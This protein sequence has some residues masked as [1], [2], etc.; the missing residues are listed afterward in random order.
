MKAI[1][2]ITGNKGKFSE[3]QEKAKTLDVKIIQKDL[4]YPEIQT[5]SLEE[6]ARYGVEYIQ[7][8]FPH[9]FVIEDAGIFIDALDGFPGVYSKYVFYSIGL[10]GILKLLKDKKNRKAVFRSIYAYVEPGKEPSFFNGEC[11]G[12][13]TLEERGNGGFGYDPVFIPEGEAKTFAEMTIEEKN[14]FFSM[15]LLLFG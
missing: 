6:V 4:G 14:S 12:T 7:G 11:I 8:S 5:D 13:I 2:F 3:L 1:Y 9:S 10:K 15:C